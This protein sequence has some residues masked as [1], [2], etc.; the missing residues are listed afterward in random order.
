MVS[1]IKT[2]TEAAVAQGFHIELTQLP[3][4]GETY[5]GI[6]SMLLII[7]CILLLGVSTLFKNEREKSLIQK[8]GWASFALALI[9]ILIYVLAPF[10][11]GALSG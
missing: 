5:L 8:A 10:V 1:G 6:F 11:V 2:L 7:L 9:L 3:G 4:R